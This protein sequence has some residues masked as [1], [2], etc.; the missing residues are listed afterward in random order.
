[1]ARWKRTGRSPWEGCRREVPRRPA[2]TVD[3]GSVG[4]RGLPPP[5][6]PAPGGPPLPVRLRRARPGGRGRASSSRRRRSASTG[7]SRPRRPYELLSGPV[8]RRVAQALA[9]PTGTVYLEEGR[10]VGCGQ[11]PEGRSGQ[12]GQ[13]VVGAGPRSRSA[14]RVQANQ[15]SDG[16]TSA[17]GRTSTMAPGA[18]PSAQAKSGSRLVPEARARRRRPPPG[19]PGPPGGGRRRTGV[20]GRTARTAGSG[21]VRR[22]RPPRASRPASR[23]GPRASPAARRGPSA[24]GADQ[25]EPLACRGVGGQS[26]A[27]PGRYWSRPGPAPHRSSRARFSW[28]DPKRATRAG[29]PG[30]SRGTTMAEKYSADEPRRRAGSGSVTGPPSSPTSTGSSRSS[31]VGHLGVAAHGR[32][33][34]GSTPRGVRVNSGRPIW[35]SSEPSCW[36]AAGWDRP[37]SA[38]PVADRPGPVDGNEGPEPLRSMPYGRAYSDRPDFALPMVAAERMLGA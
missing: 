27:G 8:G 9:H 16:T 30:P 4:L 2:S 3:A 14:A 38:A 12:C 32:G 37:R 7:G 25:H 28:S 10:P 15:G 26:R 31:G 19:G 17:T 1:M 18:S 21:A 20:R 22:C 6:T 23:R 11:A 5:P 35:R 33:R 36:L 13:P 34:V 24:P 29:T